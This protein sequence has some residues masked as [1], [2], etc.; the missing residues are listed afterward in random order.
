MILDDADPDE[1][2]AR[3]EDEGAPGDVDTIRIRR[4]AGPQNTLATLELELERVKSIDTSDLQCDVEDGCC[5]IEPAL[6]LGSCEQQGVPPAPAQDQ[7]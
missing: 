6:R 3:N 1:E 7:P 2:G 5:I 4:N